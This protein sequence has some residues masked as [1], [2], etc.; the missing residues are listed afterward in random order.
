MYLFLCPSARGTKSIFRQTPCLWATP[1]P[2][3]YIFFIFLVSLNFVFRLFWSCLNIQLLIKTGLFRNCCLLLWVC[4]HNWP[5]LDRDCF[6][7]AEGIQLFSLLVF[8]ESNPNCC[9]LIG[10]IIISWWIHNGI[11]VPHR[12]ITFASTVCF[13]IATIYTWITCGWMVVQIHNDTKPLS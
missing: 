9:L 13:L 10:S 1:W 4:S 11:W 12:H 3:S 8:M 2:N 7:R 6:L 5:T